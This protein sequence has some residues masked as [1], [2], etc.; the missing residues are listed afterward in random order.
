MT[1]QGRKL[2]VIDFSKQCCLNATRRR[3][4]L[5]SCCPAGKIVMKDMQAHLEKLRT[6]PAECEM[7]AKLAT[8]KARA[9]RQARRA[10]SSLGH[11]SRA[12]QSSSGTRRAPAKWEFHRRSSPGFTRCTISRYLC[13]S[14]KREQTPERSRSSRNASAND[15][16]QLPASF[17]RSSTHEPAA[18]FAYM[19]ASVASA[20]GT[21]E[22]TL[23]TARPASDG[24]IAGA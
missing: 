22:A 1:A 12:R 16:A 14:W 10:L 23:Q 15:A 18:P 7:I 20:S 8:D 13:A 17:G 11:R 19:N 9:V 6:E 3:M 24:V 21:I 2:Q 4:A 5:T